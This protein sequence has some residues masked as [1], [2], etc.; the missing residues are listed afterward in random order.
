MV[1][2]HAP[3]YDNFWGPVG[4][5][6]FTYLRNRFGITYAPVIFFYIYINTYL[7]DKKSSMRLNTRME[8]S[9]EVTN[10]NLH[11]CWQID[12]RGSL[13][14]TIYQ[15]GSIFKLFTN[16]VYFYM[17]PAICIDDKAK[18]SLALATYRVDV[19][20]ISPTALTKQL[21]VSKRAGMVSLSWLAK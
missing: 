16:E 13:L 21:L 3:I 15:I 20:D 1:A 4:A 18:F 11:E 12:L 8:I 10:I 19:E 5:G 2:W 6:V 7:A 14:Q 17:H 9:H